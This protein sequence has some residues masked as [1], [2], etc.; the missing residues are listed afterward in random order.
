ME[1]REKSS[2]RECLGSDVAGLPVWLCNCMYEWIFV[3]SS[4]GLSGAALESCA[5]LGICRL[6]PRERKSGRRMAF[7]VVGTA[8]SSLL[9]RRSF[10]WK[11]GEGARAVGGS[12]RL[13][14]FAGDTEGVFASEGGFKRSPAWSIVQ[15]MSSRQVLTSAKARVFSESLESVEVRESAGGASVVRDWV[16]GSACLHAS[17]CCT[18]DSAC[19]VQV[20]T[21]EV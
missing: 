2:P 11:D 21:V 12:E 9:S 15:T 10:S 8:L 20:M 5:G 4:R 17:S 19:A 16:V 13:R 14:F 18:V 3:C 1:A 6:K 7:G